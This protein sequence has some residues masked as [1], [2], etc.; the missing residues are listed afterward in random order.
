[1]RVGDVKSNPVKAAQTGRRPARA[2]E[3]AGKGEPTDLVSLSRLSETLR[4]GGSNDAKVERLRQAVQTGV[5][6]ALADQVARKI[7]DFYS[8]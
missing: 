1:M 2:P 7:L 3:N 5:Y 6:Q 8:A 4:K